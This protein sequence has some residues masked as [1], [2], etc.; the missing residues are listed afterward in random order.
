MV[1]RV[2]ILKDR[3]E[4]VVEALNE[5]KVPWRSASGFPRNVRSRRRYD[6]YNAALLMTAADAHGFKSP[7]WGSRIQ[8]EVL[9]GRIP[10][11]TGW[12]VWVVALRSD[13]GVLVRHPVYNLEQV[14]GVLPAARQPGLDREYMRKVL[15]G[16]GADIRLT[17]DLVAEYH[18]P[19]GDADGD[20]DYI[21]ICHKEYFEAGPCGINAFYHSLMHELVGHWTEPDHRVGWRDAPEVNE[22]RAEIA[23][24]FMATEM[25]M[26]GFPSDARRNVSKHVA[27]WTQRLRE[28][29]WLLWKVAHSAAHAV[30]YVLA[31]TEYVDPRHD[32]EQD[33][34]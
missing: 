34:D 24:D 3:N 9:G 15:A 8:W 27:V 31:F 30:D 22:L 19:G 17:H 28:D 25:G 4:T 26:P 10:A 16:A 5:Q 14:E 20:G 13:F 33:R 6:G 7:Y 21:K 32:P 18:L 2:Q 23:S 29:P 11:V 12:D 1:A